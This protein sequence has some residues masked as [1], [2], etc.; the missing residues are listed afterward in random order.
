[1][2]NYCGKCL[3]G[4]CECR[5]KAAWAKHQAVLDEIGYTVVPCMTCSPCDAKVFAYCEKTE[6]VLKNSPKAVAFAAR[7]EARK[8]FWEAVEQRKKEMAEQYG[9][10]KEHYHQ[11]GLYHAAWVLKLTQ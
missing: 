5:I 1:M 8:P 4:G 10:H 9:G 6:R 3:G 11:H 2:A 7:L